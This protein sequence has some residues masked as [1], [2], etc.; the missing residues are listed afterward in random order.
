MSDLRVLHKEV[1]VRVELSRIRLWLRDRWRT[2]LVSLSFGLVPLVLWDLYLSKLILYRPFHHWVYGAVFV[3][4]GVLLRKR[5]AGVLLTVVGVTWIMYDYQDALVGLVLGESLQGALGQFDFEAWLREMASRFGYGGVAVASFLGASSIIIPIPY[6]VLLFWL[7]STGELN[8]VLL[9]V[10]AGAGAALGELVGYLIGYSVQP[11][12]GDERKRK[13][14]ALL[15][16][17]E[18]RNLTLVVIFLF[19]LTP[20]P[21]DLLFLPLGLV[22]FS[23]WKAL[24]PAFLGKTVMSFIISYSGSL[25]IELFPEAGGALPVG[26]ITTAALF[27]VLILMWRTDW[28]R[29]LS[30]FLPD[31]DQLA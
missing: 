3:V 23:I 6:T 9:A 31:K 25:Y 16:L 1:D 26:I 2:I 30:R 22:Q 29:V 7:G 5:R 15:R 11:F 28:E 19:A 14:K 12:V 17:V 13:F 20:L 21:D 10:A 24:L 8:L 27:A 4:V 18:N